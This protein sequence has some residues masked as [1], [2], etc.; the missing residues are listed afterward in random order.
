MV[1]VAPSTEVMMNL[2]IKLSPAE[3]IRRAL[4][5]EPS[6]THDQIRERLGVTQ[7]QITAALTYKQ[8]GSKRGG[9]R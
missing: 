1:G 2:A 6:L 7:G 5:A 4:E 9:R 3:R 8:P